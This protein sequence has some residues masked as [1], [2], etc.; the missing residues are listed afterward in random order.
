LIFLFLFLQVT[1]K[2]PKISTVRNLSHFDVRLKQFHLDLL[3]EKIV[4][5][6]DKVRSHLIDSLQKLYLS[7]ENPFR[8]L[9]AKWTPE[10]AEAVFERMRDRKPGVRSSAFAFICHIAKDYI[11]GLT[12][13]SSEFEVPE[14]LNRWLKGLVGNVLHLIYVPDPEAR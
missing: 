10:L 3:K 4:D 12:E 5:P 9:L 13:P 6:D 2:R 8:T 11:T 1:L 7:Q 14:M